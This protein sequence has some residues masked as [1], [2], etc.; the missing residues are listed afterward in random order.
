M[1]SRLAETLIPSEII[2]L[3]AEVKEKAALGQ[4][5]YNFTIGDFDPLIFP[6]PDK[7]EQLIIEAY[8]N[9]KTNYP[10]ANG[11]PELRK[12]ISAYINRYEHL[13]YN[14]AEVLISGGG[15]PLI[16]AA[17]RAI[18]DQGDKV[19]F[20]I[21]SWNNNHYT[22]FMDG[23]ACVIETS[24]E[25][26]FL[27]TAQD[28]APHIHGTTLIA[29]CSPL[30]PTGTVFKR[31][32]LEAICDLV[33]EENKRRGPNEKKL[34]IL[35]DQIYWTL[36]FGDNA[37]YNPVSI[38]P[39]LKEC[40]I[41]VDGMSKA[42]AA[43]GVRVG[44]ALGPE[45]LLNKMRGLLSHIGSWCPMAEQVAA[46]KFLTDY[47]AIDA[48]MLHFKKEIEIRLVGIYEGFMSLKNEGFSI[49]CIKPQAS[50][51]LTVR[52][53]LKGKILPNG[54]LITQTQQITSFLL[55]ECSLA[56]VPFFA[57][58][59]DHE[60]N[61]FRLSIGTCVTAEIPDMIAKLR[62]GLQKLS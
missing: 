49:D 2:K 37:H 51:Y 18:V 48:F 41:M 42:F 33:V 53:D 22:H 43:T 25:N 30:N 39:Q 56:L 50:I 24:P 58:G 29:L 38:R 1:L 23:N 62:E 61:W 12:A 7:F 21:P 8:Q 20:P 3:A 9:K 47:D 10:A 13:D 19:I 32:Q 26:D 46:A 35:F 34:H 40:T 6:I 14:P 27:P 54:E 60:S 52:F 28:L 57:F 55:D 15:R 31:A 45:R 11:I 17:Y 44:W 36:T 16:Y 4:K 59:S 5:I